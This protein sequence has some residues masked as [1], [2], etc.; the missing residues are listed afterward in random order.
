MSKAVMTIHGFLTDTKD[1]GRLYDYLDFYDEVVAY[2]VPG[3]NDGESFDNFTVE[4]TING[5]LACFDQL[6]EKYDTVDV[7]GFSMGGALTSYLCARRAVNKAVFIAPSNRYF[8]LNSPIAMIKFY[9]KYILRWLNAKNDRAESN[10]E[11]RRAVQN[12]AV[13]AGIAIKRIF[14]SVDLHTFSVF[15]DLMELVCDVVDIKQTVLTDSLLLWG[16]LDELVPRS[17]VEYIQKHFPNAESVIYDDVGHAMLY[18]NRD[19]VIIQKI[20]GFLSG[21]QIVAA[22][23]FQDKKY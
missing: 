2:K 19:N 5:V 13:S 9:F 11:I 8:N 12:S 3:H 16:V 23:P 18:T 7:V 17:S 20:V 10:E 22:V 4:S 1:F 14:P 15:Q 21:G 6:A